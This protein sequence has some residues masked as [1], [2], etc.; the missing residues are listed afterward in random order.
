MLFGLKNTRATYQRAISI[1][2]KEHLRKIVE[3][4]VDDLA[5]KSKSKEDQL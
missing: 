2:F 1:V 3:C 5:I 4:Y